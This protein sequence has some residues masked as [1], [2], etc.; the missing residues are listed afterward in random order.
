MTGGHLLADATALATR[1]RC[2]RRVR[3]AALDPR[4][5]RRIA[6]ADALPASTA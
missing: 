6:S 3:A 2:E 4:R 5:L 1:W